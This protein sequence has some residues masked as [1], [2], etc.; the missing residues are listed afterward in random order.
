MRRSPHS[1]GLGFLIYRSRWNFLANEHDLQPWPGFILMVE[2]LRGLEAAY[3]QP[4]PTTSYGNPQGTSLPFWAAR[5]RR[6][7]VMRGTASAHQNP[8]LYW[9]I[10]G[11]SLALRE[12]GNGWMG[13]S[14]LPFTG[15]ETQAQRGRGVVLRHTAVQAKSH[16]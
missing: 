5:L 11:R 14:D 2:T 4:C 12:P 10:S 1:G 8:R 16:L 9:L 6:L 15:K 3:P 13:V 7:A